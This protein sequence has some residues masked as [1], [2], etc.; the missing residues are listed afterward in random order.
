MQSLLM[1]AVLSNAAVAPG[2]CYGYYS[3][4][5]YY[6]PVAYY[7]V[8]ERV[9]T[10]GERAPSDTPTAE[11]RAIR[12]KLDELTALLTRMDRRL[13]AAE[14]RFAALESK[15][16]DLVR[17]FERKEDLAKA[18]EMALA[19]IKE[20]RI[21]K[22]MEQL[23]EKTAALEND[24]KFMAHQRLEALHRH[25]VKL[26]AHLTRIEKNMVVVKNDGAKNGGTRALEA[27]YTFEASEDSGSEVPD[28]RALIVVNLPENAKLFL[29]GQQRQ[30]S[31]RQRFILTPQLQDGEYYYTLRVDTDRDGRVQSQTRQISFRRG[32][33]V[34]VSFEKERP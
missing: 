24:H 18:Q 4:P 7:P 6:V 22:E 26:E 25:L 19:S 17:T 8:V 13:E 2:Q 9:Y 23:R 29:N 10:T 15:H 27:A 21:R 3:R 12:K 1:M 33:Q 14:R 31:S 5:V 20:E 16:Q 34:R 28:S 30:G 32:M 11:G